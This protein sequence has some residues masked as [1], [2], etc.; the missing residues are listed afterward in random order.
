M[1]K[2]QSSE[3]E[4]QFRD[5]VNLR[6]ALRRR[7]ADEPQLPA[8]FAQKLQERIRAEREKQ[9]ASIRPRR[10]WNVAAIF[11]GVLLMSGVVFAVVQWVVPVAPKV[12]D[13]VGSD[14]VVAMKTKSTKGAVVFD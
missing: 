11:V 6:E 2:N 5:D 1:K 9:Q 10:W 8:D 3:V 13:M 7:Y 4:Q 14:S 12:G